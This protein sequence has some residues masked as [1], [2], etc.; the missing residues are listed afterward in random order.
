MTAD[1]EQMHG[2]GNF[3]DLTAQRFRLARRR[4]RLDQARSGYNLD[5][6]R[7]PAKAGDQLGLF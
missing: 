2:S 3:A 5:L 4:L 1:S 7:V 6:F